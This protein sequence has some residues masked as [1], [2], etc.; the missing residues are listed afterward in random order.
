MRDNADNL[1][2]AFSRWI[3]TQRQAFDIMRG[4][5]PTDREEDLVE[6]HRWIT[7]ISRLVLDWVVERGD[8][9]R[10][11]LFRCQDEHNKLMADNPDVTYHFCVLDPGRTYRLHGR[12]GGASYLGLTFGSDIFGGNDRLG[13]TTAQY[14][15]DS[16]DLPADGDF[17]V[18]LGGPATAGNHVELPPDTAHLAIRETFHDRGTQQPASMAVDLLD[19]VGPPRLDADSFAR[20][21]DRAGNFML[22]IVNMCLQTYEMTGLLVN[23][24]AGASGESHAEKDQ[25]EIS[26]HSNAEMHYVGGRFRLEPGK[27]LEIRIPPVKSPFTY[28]GLTLLSPWLESYDYRYRT[29]SMNDRQASRDPDGGWTMVLADTDPGRPNWLDAGGRS[30]GMML[31]RWVKVT[32]PPLPECHLVDL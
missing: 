2:Q 25:G 17:E 15:L 32:D 21:L 14:D 9:L 28:W 23:Q 3:K 19:P 24:M 1:E 8:P 29:V 12:R 10:P 7:R 18:T 6:G 27:A 16:F 20:S 22:T 30:E 31:L 13:G 4:A 5:A 26:G 11:V